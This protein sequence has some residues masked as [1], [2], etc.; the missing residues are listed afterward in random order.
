M[1]SGE[2]YRRNVLETE[3]EMTMLWWRRNGKKWLVDKQ[4]NFGEHTTNF[5][6]FRCHIMYST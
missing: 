2:R 6:L 3:I 5:T 4:Q 1:Q